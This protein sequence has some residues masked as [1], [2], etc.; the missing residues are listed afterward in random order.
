MYWRFFVSSKST[1]AEAGWTW[2]L[3]RE[4]HVAFKTAARHFS[5]LTD[6]MR[7]AAAHGYRGWSDDVP[8]ADGPLHEDRMP[9]AAIAMPSSYFR[10]G[11]ERLH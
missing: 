9:M 11:N 2:E 5:T 4:N 7:D 8:G 10:P 1:G 6:C 3:C